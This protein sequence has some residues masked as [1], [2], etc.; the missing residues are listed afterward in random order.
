MP[1]LPAPDVVQRNRVVG[2]C[3]NLLMHIDDDQRKNHFFH[4]DL[5]DGF[6]SFGKMSGRIAVRPPLSDMRELL[7]EKAFAEAALSFLVPVNGVSR[8][9]RKSW[10]VRNSRF[11]KRASDRRTASTG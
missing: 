1:P 3:G 8:L 5:V 4:I 7:G 10:P 2:I 11:R 6:F 9:S